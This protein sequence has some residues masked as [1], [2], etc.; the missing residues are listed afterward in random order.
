MMPQPL[1]SMFQ[2]FPQPVRAPKS[3]GAVRLP[4]PLQRPSRA[5]TMRPSV[6]ASG[7]ACQMAMHPFLPPTAQVAPQKHHTSAQ[8]GLQSQCLPSG[9]TGLR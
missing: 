7:A 4:P 2:S 9:V 3:I 6:L 8:H 5:M 1:S